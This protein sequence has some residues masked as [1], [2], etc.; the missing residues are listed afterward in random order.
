RTL[1][2][3]QFNDQFCLLPRE[4][5]V[6]VWRSGGATGQPVFY[7]R[8]AAD[9]GYALT[10]FQ[11]T[12]GVIGASRRDMVHISFPLGIHPV[13]TLMARCAEQ[14]G[15]ATLWAGAGNTTPSVMQL[16]LLQ[17]LRPTI[18]AGMSSYALHLANLA[19][20]RGI[21]LAAGSV[22][23]VLVS[24]EQLTDAK[25]AKIARAWGA[26]VYDSFGMTEAAMIAVEGPTSVGRGMIAYTDMYYLEVI[27]EATGD[28]VPEGQAGSLLVTTLWS[29][30][31]T[32][33]IRWK[34]GD[35]VSLT[36]Q[37]RWRGDPYSVFPILK[38]AHR[39][40]GFFKIKG[41]NVNHT[42]F[43]DIIFARP[44]IADFKCE[45]ITRNDQELMRVVV[46]VKRGVDGAAAA[47]ALATAIK[48]RFES[49]PDVVVQE[50]GTIAREFETSVKA[51]RF[52]D[53]RT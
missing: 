26:T 10:A 17:S 35:F 29:N 9:M 52:V 7:P 31:V 48:E 40:S 16:E 27:D 23:T 33:F 47:P 4:D 21:D 32:P 20:A 14:E 44:E 49:T 37:Q 13:G 38:H 5:I 42:E 50:L 25:R 24:A 18:W 12:W 43:E 51:P 3:A 36:R 8:S 2:P 30:A 22:S 34:S 46:E 45:L 11:R 28:P 19:E 53:K 1:S 15:L 39:T 6:E 41:V